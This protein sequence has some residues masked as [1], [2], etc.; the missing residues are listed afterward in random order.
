[1]AKSNGC[2]SNI[3]FKWFFFKTRCQCRGKQSYYK[4]SFKFF[5]N[6]ME[7]QPPSQN[8]MGNIFSSCAAYFGSK[9]LTSEKRRGPNIKGIISVGFVDLRYCS[10][11][12]I[13]YSS[14]SFSK[15]RFVIPR[16]PRA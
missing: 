3:V 9:S 5:H 12:P 16:S 7:S 2:A 1:P 14:P 6:Y 4:C 8:G 10:V 11:V 13:R 15:T